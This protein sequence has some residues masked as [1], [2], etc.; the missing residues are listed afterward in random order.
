M[1][2]PAE[3]DFVDWLGVWLG[4]SWF[5]DF[6]WEEGGTAVD[7]TGRTI[8]FIVSTSAGVAELTLST[9]TSGVA[10]LSAAGGQFRVSITP[11]QSTTLGV[12]SR[13][14]RLRVTT[15]SDVRTLA[16]GRFAVLG[17]V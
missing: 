8:E 12:G 9:A 10:V 7:L 1:S 4:D 14:Y 2:T 6:T 17:G 15:G 13:F 5:R 11:T 16:T 3:L